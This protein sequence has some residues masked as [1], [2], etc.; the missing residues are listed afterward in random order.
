M[1][2]SGWSSSGV[3]TSA[4]PSSEPAGQASAANCDPGADRSEV[5]VVEQ[6]ALR[7]RDRDDLASSLRPAW[8][9]SVAWIAGW[10]RRLSAA[11]QRQAEL[12]REGEDRR[13]WRPGSGRR[14]SASA[15]CVAGDRGVDRERVA[16]GRVEGEVR[17]GR[18]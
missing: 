15:P 17:A 11:G 8:R 1:P 18:G 4:L 14:R 5:G 3:T 13:S 2:V 10:P 9:C 16:V 7:Q 12:R 6:L